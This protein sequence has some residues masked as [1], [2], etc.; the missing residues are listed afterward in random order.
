MVHTENN[1]KNGNKEVKKILFQKRNFGIKKRILTNG[2]VSQEMTNQDTKGV[3]KKA[4]INEVMK[5]EPKEVKTK[6]IK[7][8]AKETKK[9]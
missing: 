7:K 5:N 4:S 9:W 2:E 3:S 6:E 8:T 1:F